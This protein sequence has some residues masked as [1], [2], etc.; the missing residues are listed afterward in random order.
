MIDFSALDRAVLQTLQMPEDGEVYYQPVGGSRR[1][2]DDVIFTSPEAPIDGEGLR[3]EGVGPQFHVHRD[4]CPSL[5]QGDIFERAGV[6]YVVTSV[7][8]DEGYMRI[9]MCRRA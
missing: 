7:R 4:D 8:R 1:Q 3:F 2:L 5:A 6:K 9:A